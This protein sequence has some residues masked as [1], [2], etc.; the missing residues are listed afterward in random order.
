MI[1]GVVNEFPIPTKVPPVCELY[2]FIVPEDAIAPRLTVP[3]SQRVF[4]VDAVILG[5]VTIVAVTADRGELVQP[6]VVAST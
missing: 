3:E 5:V 1:F 6:E 2:Q 4:G